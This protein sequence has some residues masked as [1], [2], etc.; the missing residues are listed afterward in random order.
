MIFV[1]PE[2]M[3]NDI[4][5]DARESDTLKVLL[6]ALAHRC[7]WAPSERFSQNSGG[8]MCMDIS[9]IHHHKHCT[10]LRAEGGSKAWETRSVRAWQ[11]FAGSP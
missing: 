1:Y 7:A 6:V 9:I 2:V 10:I 4:V 3:L 8:I 5:E 11:C